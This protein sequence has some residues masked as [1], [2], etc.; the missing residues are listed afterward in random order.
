MP[1]HPNLEA[2]RLIVAKYSCGVN[3]ICGSDIQGCLCLAAA[4]EILALTTEWREIAEA[5]KD[6][7]ILVY[8][9]ARQGLS[10]LF[11]LCQWH[12]DAGFCVDELREPTHFMLLPSPP[13]E[14][15]S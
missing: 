7:L 8:C 14:P 6:K 2:A 9:P 15:K 3:I 1:D 12:E 11:S 4:R 10:P 13:Q 5:P